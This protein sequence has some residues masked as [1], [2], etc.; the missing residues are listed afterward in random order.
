MYNH[1]TEDHALC[2]PAPG[3]SSSTVLYTGVL[4]DAKNISWISLKT[5]DPRADEAPAHC[6][7]SRDANAADVEGYMGYCG[8]S[9]S[10]YPMP[11]RIC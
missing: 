5:L 3:R 11:V 7:W 2:A 8:L 9:P 6:T 4:C 1:T 10:N